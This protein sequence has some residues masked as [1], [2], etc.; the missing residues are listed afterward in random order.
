M[1]PGTF[2]ILTID[3]GGIRGVFPAKFLAAIE[4]RLME[5][6]RSKT[7]IYEHFDFIS[8]TSTGGIIAIALSLGIPAKEILELYIDKAEEIF[9]KKRPWCK[10]LTFSKFDNAALEKNIRETFSNHFNG[11]DPRLKDCKVPVCVPTFDL[12]KGEPSV[13]KSNYHERFIRD[14]HIP[15]F[16][17]AMATS[18]APTFFDPFS[19][20]YQKIGSDTA[21]TFSNKVDG[22]VFAN[23]P[24]L[25]TLVEVQK[26]FN[27][28]L[29]DIRI[30]SIG[31][32]S[33]KYSDANKRKLW[34]PLY[35]FNL[36]RRR[37]IDL[38]MQAQSQFTSNLIS[39]LLK[40]I[41]KV[42][43]E[44]FNYMRIDTSFDSDFD[45]RLDETDNDR[46]TALV[47]KAAVEFQNHG[48]KV[49]EL[50]CNK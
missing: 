32:G 22:G 1:M 21:E 6:G 8:G 19:G 9:G 29:K 16:Q 30:L 45:V 41:D 39:L 28:D 49:V 11:D 37:I 25:L 35:W 24:T 47:E 18:A 5:L 40:G 17:A 48:N 46:L 7:K 20:T 2:N 33:R 4:D 12:L 43:N 42:E 50:F 31:T 38:F 27:K 26:A 3:G 44:N 13:L 23:N 10:R 15:A 34:G 14:Y 36:R